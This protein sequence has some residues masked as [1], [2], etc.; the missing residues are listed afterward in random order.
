MQPSKAVSE[1]IR[2]EVLKRL[3]QVETGENVRLLFAVESGSRAWGFPS[4]DSDYDVRFVYVR[5]VEDYLR[6]EEVRDVIERPI[7]DEIDLNGWDIKK[8]LRLMLKSNAV[9]S[10][11][12]Q[13]PIMYRADA[14]SVQALSQLAD[15][16][17]SPRSVGYHYW[18]LAKRQYER[19]FEGRTEVKLKRYFYV[20]RP[21]LALR[22]LRQNPTCRV[23]MN[24]QKL[25][26]LAELDDAMQAEIADLVEIKVL[27]PELGKGPRR[28]AIDALITEEM[29]LA[30]NTV[31]Q[32]PVVFAGL[33]AEADRLF[34]RIVQC[35]KI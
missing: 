22:C 21:A 3:A 27:T 11:W 17:L 20:L 28:P 33:S 35:E 18:R 15:R 6:L 34:Q 2:R 4:P 29:R 7:V 9:I 24:L 19:L 26:D 10:E 12:L 1:G 23:P 8:A 31:P 30:E 5:P 25:V 14:D 13:S 32:M 16:V